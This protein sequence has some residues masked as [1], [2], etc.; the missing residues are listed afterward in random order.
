MAIPAIIDTHIRVKKEYLPAGAE[1]EIKGYLSIRNQE[2]HRAI[3]EQLQDALELPDYIELWREN[4]IDQLVL[5]RGFMSTFIVGMSKDGHSISWTDDR[6]IVPMDEEFQLLLHPITLREHQEPAVRAMLLHEQGIY[7]APPGSGKTVTVLEAIRRSRQRAIILTDKSHL[8]EQWRQRAK[9]FLGVEIGLIGDKVFDP[10]EIT[11]ALKQTLW[12]RR[13]DLAKEGFFDEWGFVAY[14]ECH[15]VTADTYQFIIQKFPAKYLIGVSATPK[16][17]P[18][19]F[20]IAEGL[21]GPIFHETPR[22]A[23]QER[24]I[25]V[26]PEIRVVPTSFEFEFKGTYRNKGGYR[27]GNNYQKMMRALTENNERNSLIAHYINENRN[28]RCLVVS[29]RLNH[30]DR[31]AQKLQ[32]LGYPHDIIKMTGDTPRRERMDIYEHAN[33]YHCCIFSTV[34]D[35]ALDIP[36]LDRIFLVWPTRNISVVRQQVG[37]IER[38][39]DGKNSAIAYDFFD[40]RVKVLKSQFYDRLSGVYKAEEMKIEYEGEA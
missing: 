14:D 21:L 22:E 8:A 10:G 38:A 23:L 5:P 3:R 36:M 29:K 4:A 26:E 25:L 34:A 37:R 7:Q 11:V 31:I 16:R 13:W 6:E 2:K 9:Q 24:G 32:D 39:A 17:V 30:L 1:E 12:S 35:E 20:P 33:K 18:W 40:A 28:K 19:T 27:V 15:H